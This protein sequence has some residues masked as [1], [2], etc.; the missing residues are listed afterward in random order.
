MMQL[1]WAVNYNLLSLGST[2]PIVAYSGAQRGIL[3]PGAV[4][5]NFNIEAANRGVAGYTKSNFI[6]P[7]DPAS[8]PTPK[9]PSSG[10]NPF[11]DGPSVV[12]QSSGSITIPYEAGCH[13]V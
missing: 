3:Y 8:E 6:D 10:A 12:R 11:W 5:V 4:T 13:T 1:A 9:T 2:P 7:G